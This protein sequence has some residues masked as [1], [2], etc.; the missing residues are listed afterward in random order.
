MTKNIRLDEY[1][2]KLNVNQKLERIDKELT[3]PTSAVPTEE[4]RILMEHIEQLN[5]FKITEAQPY[6]KKVLVLKK[7]LKMKRNQQ[8][9]IFS[10]IG[11]ES[12]YLLGKVTAVGRDFVMLTNLKNRMWIPFHTIESANIPYGIPNYTNSHQH[13]LYDNNLRTKLITN[14]GATV[15]KRDAL[16]QQFFEE[17]LRTNLQSYIGS[18]VEVTYFN[19]VLYGKIT[20]I[21]EDTLKMSLFSK[22]EEIPIKDIAYIS[23]LRFQQFITNMF[24]SWKRKRDA[25]KSFE[26]GRMEYE[27]A[28]K[29]KSE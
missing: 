1:I 23:T 18:W 3:S 10:K 28:S 6:R 22:K 20:G 7:F 19:N 25:I 24:F 29:T 4:T 21:T 16:I 9:E 26:K 14:F 17:T 5:L 12:K 8:V 11:G 15:A 2:K 13:N 27:E